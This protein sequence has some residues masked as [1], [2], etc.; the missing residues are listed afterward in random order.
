[1]RKASLG[2]W[3]LESDLESNEETEVQSSLETGLSRWPSKLTKK[4][5]AKTSSQSHY[6]LPPSPPNHSLVLEDPPY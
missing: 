4:I 6:I 2:Q 1:M 5:G 3:D